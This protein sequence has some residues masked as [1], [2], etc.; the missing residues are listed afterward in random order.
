MGITAKKAAN[1]AA[2]QRIEGPEMRPPRPAANQDDI[3]S[4]RQD[5]INEPSIAQAEE[6]VG[7]RI[8]RGIGYQFEIIAL[9]KRDIPRDGLPKAGI[10]DGMLCNMPRIEDLERHVVTLGQ[11]LIE[12]DEVLNR[13]RNDNRQP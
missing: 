9:G 7:T 4:P 1:A 11:A 10:F 12:R 13:V 2:A 8:T 5:A 3:G 6:M